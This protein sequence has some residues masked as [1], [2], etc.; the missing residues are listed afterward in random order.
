MK[1]TIPTLDSGGLDAFV[2]DHFGQSPFFTVVDTVTEEVHAI[3]NQGQ[4]FG[5]PQHPAA[6]AADAAT[7]VILCTNLGQKALRYFQQRDITVYTGVS[8]KVREILQAY[9]EG[10]LQSGTEPGSCPG[11]QH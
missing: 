11:K 5:G 2:S 3:T 1:I 7:D 6:V 9:R 8:G 10:T 4:H